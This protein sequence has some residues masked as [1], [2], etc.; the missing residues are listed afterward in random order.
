MPTYNELLD[1]INSGWKGR[2]T[3]EAGN[4]VAGCFFGASAATATMDDM[5]G[6]IFIACAGQR[7]AEAAMFSVRNGY[8]IVWS[9]AGAAEGWANRIYFTTG[10]TQTGSIQKGNAYSVRPVKM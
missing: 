3:G 4:A 10:S 9:D 1:L 2:A 5:Q 8:G 7:I 6:C